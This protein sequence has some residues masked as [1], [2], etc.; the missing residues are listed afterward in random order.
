MRRMI[1][2]RRSR[3][4]GLPWF[5]LPLA[6]CGSFLDSGLEAKLA[7]TN[8]FPRLADADTVGLAQ[9][10]IDGACLRDAHLGAVD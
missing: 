2:Q 7:A 3:T 10:A 9:S 1:W 6:G 5:P 4:F 8:R